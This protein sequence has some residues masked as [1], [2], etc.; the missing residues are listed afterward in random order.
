[1]EPERREDTWATERGWA[2]RLG[3]KLWATA[4]VLA[5]AGAMVTFYP[6]ATEWIALGGCAVLYGIWLAKQG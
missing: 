5:A 2:K 4:A 6:A 3:P 1:M